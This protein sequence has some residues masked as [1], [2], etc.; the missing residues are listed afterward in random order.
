MR[1]SWK[2]QKVRQVYL[3]QHVYER[4]RLPKSFFPTLLE[5][6]DGMTLNQKK[7][8]CFR[9]FF[10][11]FWLIYL[12][13]QTTLEDAV[14]NKR[15]AK[16]CLS[17]SLSHSA[18][19]CLFHYRFPSVYPLAQSPQRALKLRRKLAEEQKQAAAQPSLGTDAAVDGSGDNDK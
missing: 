13:R 17:L 1:D 7:V 11:F 18:F 15:A 2:F 14:R 6:L 8:C 12:P 4:D 9:P 5:Y 10:L 19:S 16:V 3:L